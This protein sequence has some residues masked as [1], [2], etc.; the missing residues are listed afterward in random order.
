[1]L[2]GMWAFAYY[3]KKRKKILISRDNFGEKP[4]FYTKTKKGFFFA[5]NTNFIKKISSDK[6]LI[7]QNKVNS[8]LKYGFRSFG[9]DDCSFFK[10][11]FELRSGHSLII[12]E[13]LNIKIFKNYIIKKSYKL[14]N[15][16]NHNKLIK[17]T[18]IDSIKTR[19]NADCKVGLLLS[20]GLDSNLIVHTIKKIL[21][22]NVNTYSFNVNNN[23]KSL[24]ERNIAYSTK[25]LKTKHKNIKIKKFSLKEILYITRKIGS[26][27]SAPNFLLYY[28]LHQQAKKDNCKVVMNGFG[29][30]EIFGGYFSHQIFYILSNHNNNK[31]NNLIKIFKKNFTKVLYNPKLKNVDS[32][33][34]N[35]K[36][37]KNLSFYLQDIFKKEISKYKIRE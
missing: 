29:A 15:N 27:I 6:F 30:D 13:Q 22:K 17:K 7:N 9:L 23:K 10:N 26:P 25:I 11:I 33:I 24:E 34:I 2:D 35:F 36:R 12:D 31:I 18:I 4:L 5:S 28:R 21:K 1:M 20:G 19:Y 37:I 3:S 8:Y 14:I 32:L 16:N